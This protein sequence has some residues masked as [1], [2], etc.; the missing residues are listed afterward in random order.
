MV[1]ILSDSSGCKDCMRENAGFLTLVTVL[2]SLTPPS[3]I[4]ESPLLISTEHDKGSLGMPNTTDEALNAPSVEL[5]HQK[6][7]SSSDVVEINK[8]SVSTPSSRPNIFS[9]EDRDSLVELVFKCLSLSLMNDRENQHFFSTSVGYKLVLDAIRLSSLIPNSGAGETFSNRERWKQNRLCKIERL[10]GV[11]FAFIV[12]DFSYTNLFTALRISVQSEEENK[13]LKAIGKT[14]GI[15]TPDFSPSKTCKDP[16]D[17]LEKIFEILRQRIYDRKAHLRVEVADAVILYFSL[18]AD[19]FRSSKFDPSLLEV[20]QE[21]YLI[22]LKS[23]ELLAS[24]SRQ[25]QI[26]LNSIEL[27]AI[28]L[29]RMVP[30]RQ[31][32][33]TDPSGEE[34][35]QDRPSFPS[36]GL[37]IWPTEDIY[38][39]YKNI[40]TRTLVAHKRRCREAERAL[41]QILLEVG[42]SAREARALFRQAVMSSDCSDRASEALN[43]DFLDLILLGMQS[44]SRPPFIHFCPSEGSDG[45]AFLKSLGNIPFPPLQGNGWT[46]ATW[47]QI[48]S[49]GSYPN[50][51]VEIL[52]LS[53]SAQNCFVRISISDCS[54]VTVQT[55]KHESSLKLTS[56]DRMNTL[57]S[58]KFG[59]SNSDTTGPSQHASKLDTLVE[60][61]SVNFELNRFYHFAITQKPATKTSP[62]T[63]S[64][65]IDG[66]RVDTVPAIWPKS[67]GLHPVSAYF[68]NAIKITGDGSYMPST[69]KHTNPRWNLGGC[70]MFSQ[71]LVD[72]MLFVQSTLGPKIFSCFQDALGSFQT[73]TSS[74]LLNL[75]IDQIN[76]EAAQAIKSGLNTNQTP[77]RKRLTPGNNYING[78][79]LNNSPLIR[80]IKEAASV[81][82]PQTSLYFALSAKNGISL[83]QRDTLNEEIPMRSAR[84]S[85]SS[86]NSYKGNE[87]LFSH[88]QQVYSPVTPQFFDRKIF[89]S[90]ALPFG[91][92]SSAFGPTFANAVLNAA[93]PNFK[94]RSYHFYPDIHPNSSSSLPSSLHSS[95]TSSLTSAIAAGESKPHKHSNIVL[96]LVG[97]VAL[98]SPRG[99]DDSIWKA[100]FLKLLAYETIALILRSKTNLITLAV[101]RILMRLA[102]ILINGPS[103]G[104]SPACK[105][106]IKLPEHSSAFSPALKDHISGAKVDDCPVDN[107]LRESVIANPLAFRFLLLD[108]DLW[109]SAEA[110]IQL[111]HFESLRVMIETSIYSRFNIKRIVNRVMYVDI[112]PKMLRA[113]R[114]RQFSLTSDRLFQTNSPVMT[115]FIRLLSCM[116]KIQFTSESIRHLASYL[117]SSLS[118]HD[119][120]KKISHFP[121]YPQH[122]AVSPTTVPEKTLH[123]TDT[124]VF[125]G[126]RVPNSFIQPFSTSVSLEEPLMVL[127]AFHDLLMSANDQ[128][129]LHYITRFLK[130]INGPRWL[131]MFFRSDSILSKFCFRSPSIL[132]TVLSLA[133]K[134]DVRTVPIFFGGVNKTSTV[135]IMAS[136]AEFPSIVRCMEGT[137]DK[138][139]TP[140]I[141]PIIFKLIGPAYTKRNPPD[142]LISVHVMEWLSSKMAVEVWNETMGNSEMIRQWA[143]AVVLLFCLPHQGGIQKNVQNTPLESAFDATNSAFEMKILGSFPLCLANRLDQDLEV[144]SSALKSTENFPSIQTVPPS[145]AD[146]N[147]KLEPTKA[148]VC[149]RKGS[150]QVS[151]ASNKSDLSLKVDVPQ[152]ITVEGEILNGTPSSNED[153][154]PRMATLNMDRYPKTADEDFEFEDNMVKEFGGTDLKLQSYNE[155]ETGIVL[156]MSQYC[157]FF[158]ME[159]AFGRDLNISSDSGDSQ[160]LNDLGVGRKTFQSDRIDELLNLVVDRSSL[161]SAW[162]T[163]FVDKVIEMIV[164]EASPRSVPFKRLLSTLIDGYSTGWIYPCSKIVTDL[165]S[166]V[167]DHAKATKLE[168]LGDLILIILTNRYTN[169]VE[170]LLERLCSHRLA[171]VINMTSTDLVARIL[172]ILTQ[173]IKDS[174]KLSVLACDLWKLL[175]SYQPSTLEELSLGGDV[176]E[177]ILNSTRDSS[178]ASETEFSSA[179]HNESMSKAERDLAQVLKMGEKELKDVLERSSSGELAGKLN[180]IQFVTEAEYRSIRRKNEQRNDLACI[181]TESANKLKIESKR[182]GHVVGKLEVWARGVKEIDAA[183]FANLRQDHLENKHYLEIQLGK[184]LEDLYRPYSLLSKPIDNHRTYWALDSTEGPSKQRKK[185]RKIPIK[186]DSQLAQ[187]PKSRHH[188][189]RSLGTSRRDSYRCEDGSN[190]KNKRDIE[191]YPSKTDEIWMGDLEDMT[192]DET[193]NAK[194]NSKDILRKRANSKGGS[195]KF[196]QIEKSSHR[197]AYEDGAPTEDFVE[198]KF[199][200]ICKSLETND[201]VQAVWNV[202]QVIGLD[203]CPGLFLMAKNNIYII[204]GFFQKP[205]GEIVNSWDAWEDRDPHLRTLAS[206]SKQT[207]KLHSRAAA[208]QTRRWAYRDIVSMSPRKWLFRDICM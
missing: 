69:P 82:V 172:Y 7:N 34:I 169:C 167:V 138:I 156:R 134:I 106:L 127:V 86:R 178:C 152:L 126:L 39:G 162:L 194:N 37:E 1:A 20:D 193:T 157:E 84:L 141:L 124:M 31:A 21:F 186:V 89:D 2:A 60:F 206:L 190:D 63:V 197:K 93:I 192:E 102:G 143:S 57:E 168:A 45:F 123:P 72:E 16:S 177:H 29:E 129:S 62:S 90:C 55:H 199:R 131:L 79:T 187:Q 109:A 183:R 95:T 91:P 115:A 137:P 71:C 4:S 49:F 92:T 164:S 132:V 67:P 25:N 85:A 202:E 140:E 182:L 166:F 155:T 97:D 195:H 47:I 43:E 151:F 114:S 52:T 161:E 207:A 33:L 196:N 74:T 9:E 5:S 41:I 130:A 22:T 112:I 58:S 120:M 53:D 98:C 3:N 12:S 10:F 38:E 103:I 87:N 142:L 94:A 28:L 171:D 149:K 80:A 147:S 163:P 40:P 107:G 118:P 176:N 46:F 170:I 135:S 51:H 17:K 205:D 66:E 30:P 184:R 64:L 88:M 78:S 153:F 204:D 119:S 19:L 165:V 160:V 121:S 81:F 68:E 128:E 200:K 145:I 191:Q 76:H 125:D 61:N 122:E 189:M 105:N 174:D 100:Y 36:A 116:L 146:S 24:V 150:T 8:R 59:L 65:Y 203:T 201:V 32:S 139:L 15:A 110:S 83:D 14:L 23:I 179:S 117:T 54:K 198:D 173:Y 113:L 11:L 44:S 158:L 181:W 108:F 77:M 75:R 188:R 154:S 27:T 111:K 73:Y 101:H 48:E 99:L 175:T 148:H 13:N 35:N 96:R 42:S 136:D 56:P 180:W 26:T 208:H 185:L 50:N 133:S 18:H 159:F 144:N 70:W 104:S 6:R